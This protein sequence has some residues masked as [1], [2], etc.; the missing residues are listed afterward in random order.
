MSLGVREDLNLKSKRENR[1]WNLDLKQN[2]E[3]FRK[4]NL[5][6][7]KKPSPPTVEPKGTEELFKVLN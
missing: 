1:Q 3:R 2:L 5:G 4:G 7:R 6:L